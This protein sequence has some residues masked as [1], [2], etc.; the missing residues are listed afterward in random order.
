MKVRLSVGIVAVRVG[1]HSQVRELRALVGPLIPTSANPV[2]GRE[3]KV[4]C[5]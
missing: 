3:Q 1:E 5:G 2:D 4:V